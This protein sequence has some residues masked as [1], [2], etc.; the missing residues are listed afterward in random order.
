MYV[1][2]YKFD[3]LISKKFNQVDTPLKKLLFHPNFFVYLCI[4]ARKKQHLSQF[5]LMHEIY[6]YMMMT[7]RK[8]LIIISIIEMQTKT[9]ENFRLECV[10]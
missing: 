5:L 9:R 8:I 10:T 4:K 7:E 3:Q 2:L 1:Y 6:T